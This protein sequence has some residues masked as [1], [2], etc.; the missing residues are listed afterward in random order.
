MKRILSMIIAVILTMAFSVSAFAIRIDNSFKGPLTEL[1]EDE[2]IFSFG[3]T[4]TDENLTEIGFKVGGKRYTLNEAALF[5]ANQSGAFAIGLKD[6]ENILGDSYEVVPY[7]VNEAGVETTGA[8]HVVNKADFADEKSG[9]KLDSILVDGTPL[10]FFRENVKSYDYGIAYED[11]EINNPT[12]TAIAK[13]ETSEVS[14]APFSTGVNITVTSANGETDT[15][16]VNF[17]PESAGTTTK[18]AEEMGSKRRDSSAAIAPIADNA[19]TTTIRN[20]SINQA[21]NGTNPNRYGMIPY[22]TFD[23]PGNIDLQEEIIFSVRL[24]TLNTV[25]SD[26]KIY[27]YEYNENALPYYATENYGDYGYLG[28]VLN[29]EGWSAYNEVNQTFVDYSCDISDYIAKLVSLGKE[30]ATIALYYDSDVITSLW[31]EYHAGTYNGPTD[32][33]ITL[34]TNTS[35]VQNSTAVAYKDGYPKLTYSTFDSYTAKN[36]AVLSDIKVGG[37]LIAGFAEDKYEYTV[38]VEDINNLPE[39]TATAKYPNSSVNITTEGASK[40]VTVTYGT[41]VAT[42]TINFGLLTETTKSSIYQAHKQIQRAEANYTVIA[43]DDASVSSTLSVRAYATQSSSMSSNQTVMEFDLGNDIVD[44]TKGVYLTI[45]AKAN[46]ANMPQEL[47]ICA[48]E[49]DPQN[50]IKRLGVNDLSYMGELID[51]VSVSE[52]A[53]TS[54]AQYADMTFD[55]SSYVEKVQKSGSKTFKVIFGFDYDQIAEYQ[56]LYKA[57]NYTYTA[58]D[59]SFSLY[60]NSTGVNNYLGSGNAVFDGAAPRLSYKKIAD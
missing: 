6:L 14:Y 56:A 3:K 7:Y 43:L 21:A 18:I 17:K 30:K 39:V 52:R 37:T 20:T 50:I 11:M 27:A 22:I 59:Y 5:K 12:V 4:E 41:Y 46:Y 47:K 57:G 16:T 55:I 35:V 23:I 26:L 51:V 38:G 45:R 9:V 1:D 58:T 24:R 40:I 54:N 8:P 48:Y 10:S 34:V 25:P 49:Y 28:K 36:L 32:L 29:P 13:E 60:P 19:H 31:K 2:Y 42:Y 15:Y 53:S 33:S 44:T